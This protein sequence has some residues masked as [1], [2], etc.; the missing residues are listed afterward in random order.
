[1]EEKNITEQESLA[2]ISQML[3]KTRKH[4]ADGKILIKNGLI[5]SGS[6]L[7]CGIALLMARGTINDRMLVFSYLMAMTATY[8]IVFLT[9]YV[10]MKNIKKA[11][12]VTYSDSMVYRILNVVCCMSVVLT[13]Y[14]LFLGYDVENLLEISVSKIVLTSVMMSVIGN[15]FTRIAIKNE[16]WKGVSGLIV[17]LMTQIYLFGKLANGYPEYLLYTLLALSV[18]TPLFTHIIPGYRFD[19]EF[20]EAN[21]VNE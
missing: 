13:Y 3:E 11:G 15:M 21:K 4:V 8:G 5:L 17:L 18:L 12:V 9:N 19:I 1:M 6:A 16:S 14:V 2:I 20:N 7:I 10:W